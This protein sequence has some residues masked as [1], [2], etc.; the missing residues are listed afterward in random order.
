MIKGRGRTKDGKDVLIIGL[1][2]ENVT[3][4]IADE[5][6][7][8]NTTHLELPAMDVVIFYG[9]TEQD[10]ADQTVQIAMGMAMKE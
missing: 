9:K 8:F 2:G 1:S 6:I 3:R 4:L 7:L 5:P 10:I